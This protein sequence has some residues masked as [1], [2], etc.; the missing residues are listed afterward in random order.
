VLWTR[1]FLPFAGGYFLSYLYRTINA[2][3]GPGIADELALGAGAIGLLT[4]TYFLAFGAVQL[5]LG[6]LLDRLGA[7]RVE[8]ALLLVAAAGAV[9]F[10]GGHSLAELALGRALIGVGVSACLMAAFKSFAQ[11]FPPEQM[12]SLTGWIMATGGVGAL[13]STVPLEAALVWLSWR[14]IFFVLAALT[15]AAAAWIFV[16]V[17]DDARSGK[18]ESLAT[19]LAGVGA[20]FSNRHFWRFAP[21]GMLVTGGFMAVQSLWS[22]A[23][24]MQVNGY[25]RAQAAAHL[26]AMGSAMLVAYLAIGLSATRLARRGVPPVMLLGGGLGLSLATLALI[27]GEASPHTLLLWVAYGA[28]SS[29]GTLAYSQTAAG[30]PLALSGRA[31][32]AFNLLVFA[33]AFSL[34]WGIGVTIDVLLGAGYRAADAQRIAFASLLA[35]Q[36]VAYVWFIVAGRRHR[37]ARP[38]AGAA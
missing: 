4:S 7:R 32:T 24:L 2:V 33:G 29:F 27:V 15:L 20:I 38:D 9:V 6:V 37:G 11:R 3:I 22:L 28:F 16:A 36:I 12:A 35:L 5:P 13:V 21:L 31:N 8:A 30:F 14:T 26:A 18:H 25:S 17:P 1:L 34:Q 23:W 10:A 19:Q